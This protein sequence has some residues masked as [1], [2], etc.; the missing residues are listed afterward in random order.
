MYIAVLRAIPCIEPRI[1]IWLGCS[2]VSQTLTVAHVSG[3]STGARAPAPG[4]A[5]GEGEQGD[6]QHVAHVRP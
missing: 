5:D 3:G 4:A 2:S 6:E 1:P